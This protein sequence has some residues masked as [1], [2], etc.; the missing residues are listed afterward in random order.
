MKIY[1]LSCPITNNIRYVGVTKNTLSK[2][3]SQHLVERRTNKR[4]S[5]FDSLKKKGFLPTI[6]LLD[7]VDDDKWIDEEKFYIS[8][9]RFLGF[10]LVNMT[11]GGDRIEMTKEIRLK[12]SRGHTGKI[13]AQ[14]T[15]D[16]ISQ[17]NKDGR[18]GTKGVTISTDHKNAIRTYMANRVVSDLSRARMS[19]SKIKTS[20]AK[21]DLNGNEIEVY[22]SISICAKKNN[23]SKGNIIKVCK[24]KIRKD[25]SKCK[26]AYGYKWEYR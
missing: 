16:K 20:I 11:E 7:D 10:D 8:Y 5:W 23:Y 4:R 18:C 17:A 26:T 13:V 12:I 21:L 9:F 14:E 6:E 15:R 3:F 25:G 2:R 1:T 24:N 19:S 22:E